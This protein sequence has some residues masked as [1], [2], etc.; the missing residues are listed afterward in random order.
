VFHNKYYTS[1]STRS[2]VRDWYQLCTF[3]MDL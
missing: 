2:N 3:G 1:P